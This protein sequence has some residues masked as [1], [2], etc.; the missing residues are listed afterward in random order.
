MESFRVT[1]KE[2]T[3]DKLVAEYMFDSLKEAMKF[4]ASMV[5]KGYHTILERVLV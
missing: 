1:A 3:T 4:H 5:G 2:K